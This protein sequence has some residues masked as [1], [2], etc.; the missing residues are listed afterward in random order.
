MQAPVSQGCVET[1]TSTF[2]AYFQNLLFKFLD[3][4]VHPSSQLGQQP[5]ASRTVG[6]L[7]SFPVKFNTFYSQCHWVCN[8]C[9]SLQITSA[10]SDSEASGF[11]GQLCPGTP[12]AWAALGWELENG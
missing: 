7:C 9:P 3:L 8:F 4:L 11:H 1:L 6:F 5:Q 12:K 10:T 2:G